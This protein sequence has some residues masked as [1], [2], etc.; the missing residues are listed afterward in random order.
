MV[1]GLTP[2]EAKQVYEEGYKDIEIIK[3]LIREG[4]TK[5]LIAKLYNTSSNGIRLRL[6]Y[7][8]KLTSVT[9]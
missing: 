6:S 2:D 9:K 8:K 7:N 4:H 5:K 3:A 1:Y